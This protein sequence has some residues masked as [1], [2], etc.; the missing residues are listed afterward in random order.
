MNIRHE[1]KTHIARYLSFLLSAE[2]IAH[3]CASRQAKMYGSGQEKRFLIRQSRQERFHAVTFKS[4]ILWL[5]PKGVSTPAK[6]QMQQYDSLLKIA[7]ENNDLFSSILGLQIILE[8]MG[9]IALSHFDHAIEQRGL[10]YQK[11]RR[12][13][14][15]QEDS[16]HEFGL[17]YLKQH[18]LS[19]TADRYTDY[20]VDSYLSLI[21]DMLTSLQGLFDYFDEDAGS[22]L[23]EFNHKLPEP[24]RHHALDHHPDT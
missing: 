19:A 14:L 13:I 2:K 1:E 5:T 11:I 24:L 12:T 22:Y 16:H 10:G 21:N 17:N 6:K 9:D 3:H 8:G 20:N 15:T 4:A 23:K 7:T 18:S